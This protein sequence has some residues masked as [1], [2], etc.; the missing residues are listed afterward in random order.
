MRVCQSKLER[1]VEA[2]GLLSDFRLGKDGRRFDSD[3]QDAGPLVP[4]EVCRRGAE[5]AVSG[6]SVRL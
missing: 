3:G 1:E 4:E 6:S 5:W 2:L